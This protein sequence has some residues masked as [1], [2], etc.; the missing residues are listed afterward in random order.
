MDTLFTLIG[1]ATY[2]ALG[3]TALWGAFCA[4]V[5]WRRVSGTRFRDEEDQDEFLNELDSQ[6]LR[7][8]YEGAAALCEDDRR[9]LPQLALYAVENRDLGPA[10]V[11]HRLVE[12]F[13]QDVLADIEHRLSWVA[14]VIKTAPMMGLFGTVMGMMGAFSNLSSSASPD[15]GQMASDIMFALITTATGLAIALPLIIVMNSLNVRI[16]KMEDLVAAG[17]SRLLE[18]L[19]S[20]LARAS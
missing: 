8:N 13:Q 7:G 19:R 10:R 16:R 18:S 4:I 2:L 20:V 3:L 11:Q 6:L 9:A 1:N 14:T 17:I 5:V 12:R 15:P